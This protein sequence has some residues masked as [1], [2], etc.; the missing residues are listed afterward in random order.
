[1]ENL[2]EL[3][4]DICVIAKRVGVFLRE[5][6]KVFSV[7]R[8]EQKS[9]HDY[10]SY[11]DKAAEKLLVKELA[12][13][14]PD[15]GFITEENTVAQ[16]TKELNWIIDPLDGTTNYIQDNAPYCI[17]LALRNGED[18]LV[19]VVYEVCRD[20]CYAAWKGGGAYLNDKPI[21][22]TDKTIGEA[23]I[24]LDVPYNAEAY[25]H[26][27]LRLIDG[28]YG[29]VSSIRVNG[30]AAM[31]LCYVA[32]GRYDG[33]MEAFIMP[34]DYSAGVVLVREAGGRITDYNGNENIMNTHHVIASN[35]IIHDD[36]LK[37]LPANIW[38]E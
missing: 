18:L 10:V 3:T 34:W 4:A 38:S 14:L 26:I 33:W 12:G 32:A 11:V 30:S 6:R 15:A 8:V 36:L 25:R 9:S 37:L 20:E 23:F 22:V 28:L 24:G 16:S 7:D 13:L 2:K 19:G 17:S 5:E 29:K 31:G 35:K 21:R 1:M 27:L